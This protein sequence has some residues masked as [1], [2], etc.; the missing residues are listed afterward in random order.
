MNYEYGTKFT[1]LYPRPIAAI[2]PLMSGVCIET[3]PLL[4]AD[5]I[6]S[7]AVKHPSA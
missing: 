1:S 7:S 5:N 3:R 2:A 4:Y 6:I